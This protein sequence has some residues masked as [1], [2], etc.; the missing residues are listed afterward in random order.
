M[1][2]FALAVAASALRVKNADFKAV[3]EAKAEASSKCISA[4]GNAQFVATN[5]RMETRFD[6]AAALKAPKF[7][8]CKASAHVAARSEIKASHDEISQKD[9]AKAQVSVY[10]CFKNAC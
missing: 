9:S 1:K 4:T 6:F 3:S 5:D 2:F 10:N 8:K 7:E